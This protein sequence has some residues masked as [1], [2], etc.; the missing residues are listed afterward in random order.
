MANEAK[1]G[2]AIGD[3]VTTDQAVTEGDEP[4]RTTHEVRFRLAAITFVL[5]F[6]AFAAVMWTTGQLDRTALG[7]PGIWVVSFIGAG[8][9]FLPV[10]ALAAICVSAAPAVGLNPLAIGFVAGSAEALGELTGYM[11][12][13]SGNAFLERRRIY[14]RFRQWLITRGALAIFVLSAI[15]NPAFDIV[16]LAAGGLRYP[17]PRF[18]VLVFLGKVVKSTGIGYG[19]YLGVGFVQELVRGIL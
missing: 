10:P 4:K 2:E 7:L 3:S 12:G 5:L 1:T 17:I 14:P 16:G 15:P 8:S 19:C 6:I 11:A 13:L 18:L 9:I